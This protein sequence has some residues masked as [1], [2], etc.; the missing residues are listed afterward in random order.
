MFKVREKSGLLSFVLH[1]TPTL[2]TTDSK[3][4]HSN[5]N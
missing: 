2:K 5:I 3:A 4:Y 1:L